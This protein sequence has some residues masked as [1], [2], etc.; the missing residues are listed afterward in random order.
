LVPGS[1]NS[2]PHTTLIKAAIDDVRDALAAA[3]EGES[4][5]TFRS[6]SDSISHAEDVLRKAHQ[7]FPN[8]PV[9]LTQEGVLSETLSQANRT[10]KAFK[11]A[12]AA[13][14]EVL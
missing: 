6:L 5:T 10:E 13:N 11:K 4:E 1:V 14:R 9:L 2:Y 8:D 7:T 12:F 3:E